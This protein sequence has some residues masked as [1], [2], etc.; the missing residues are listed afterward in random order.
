MER[1]KELGAENLMTRRCLNVLNL[2]S[3]RSAVMHTFIVMS[4][5]L[6]GAER[7]AKESV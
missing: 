1:Y 5:P 4:E 6:F 2:S 3:W 7:R